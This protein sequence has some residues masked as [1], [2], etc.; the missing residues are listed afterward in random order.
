MAMKMRVVGHP[1]GNAAQRPR[2]WPR[3]IRWN[4]RPISSKANFLPGEHAQQLLWAFGT[5]RNYTKS[6]CST[7]LDGHDPA[8]RWR[9]DAE[10]WSNICGHPGYSI[11]LGP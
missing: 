1:R 8:S 6:L 3:S 9:I 2:S 5:A 4:R 10:L 11:V 7:P